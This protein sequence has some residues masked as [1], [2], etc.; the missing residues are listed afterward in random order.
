MTRI[1]EA[2]EAL[3]RRLRDLRREASLNGKGLAEALGWPASKVSKIE[4]GRQ[5]PSE[6]DIAAWADAC[7]TPDAIP[8]LVATV[9]NLETQYADWRRQLR[10]GT[11]LRQQALAEVDESTRTIRAFEST[12]VPGLLQT[13]EYARCRLAEVVDLYG[14]ANDID[15]GVQARME[16]QNVLYRP[17]RRFHFIITEAVL[18]Y[19]TAP[20]D[21]MT[22]QIDRLVSASSL[23][24]V[25][26]GIVPFGIRL[27][28][29]PL[30]GFWLFDDRIVM[31]ETFAAEMR[32]TQPEELRLY[33]NV[34]DRLALMSRYGSDARRLLMSALDTPSEQSPREFEK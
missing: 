7:G 6:A 13:P 19:G 8:A 9:R 22:G 3:G 1:H 17:G 23:P 15:A 20:R 11:R 28:V 21:V 27:P 26:L 34:F 33:R 4:L 24:S 2:R 29:S 14:V 30:H 5:S 18:R 31:V 25:R 12:W 32:L 10:N 16:R